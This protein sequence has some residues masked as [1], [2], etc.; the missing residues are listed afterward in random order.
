MSNW[1][2]CTSPFFRAS[3]TSQCLSEE[4]VTMY[5]L[6]T[7]PHCQEQKDR[8]G[9]SFKYV[10]Y[11]ECSVQKSLCSRKGISSVPAWI[12]DGKKIVGVQSLEKLASMTGCEYRR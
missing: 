3:A 9:G 6:K 5:G 12:I 11:V 8:F 2:T 7:C 10:D 1:A 4:G